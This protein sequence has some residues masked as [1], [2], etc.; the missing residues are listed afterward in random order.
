MQWLL[1]DFKHEDPT[2]M[3]YAKALEQ[4]GISF[5]SIG[6]IPFT[7]EITGLEGIDLGR[8]SIFMGSCQM[9][10]AVS[11]WSVKPGVFWNSDW[12]DPN[13][14]PKHRDDLLNQ[15]I[16]NLTV[17][18]IRSDWTKEVL[19]VKSIKEKVLTG[20]ILEP[21]KEDRDNWTID[22][23]HLDGTEKLISAPYYKIDAEWRFFLVDGKVITGSMYRR[24]GTRCRNYPVPKEVWDI[25][26]EKAKGWL[27]YPTVVMDIALTRN[28]GYKIIEFNSI[29]AS[30]VYSSD[31]SKLIDALENKYNG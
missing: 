7:Y 4:K 26:D 3:G 30:G 10:E 27:P 17:A 5:H 21:E 8:P 14:W 25:A 19:F 12:W 31:L 18:D 2:V 15:E 9:C 11:K 29:N 24:D 22:Y 6:I 16:N 13:E 20:M 1:L 28:H 23:S